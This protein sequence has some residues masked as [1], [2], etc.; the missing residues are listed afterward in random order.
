MKKAAAKLVGEHDF[1][2]F[3]KKD[4]TKE[5]FGYKRTIFSIDI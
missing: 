3:C 2:N 4:P 5:Q 1:R